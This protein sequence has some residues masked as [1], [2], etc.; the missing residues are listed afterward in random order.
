MCLGRAD[1]VVLWRVDD[2]AVETLRD[3]D[4]L[5]DEPGLLGSDPT[6]DGARDGVDVDVRTEAREVSLGGTGGTESRGESLS[7]GAGGG[8]SGRV[9]REPHASFSI[10]RPI[11]PSVLSRPSGRGREAMLATSAIPSLGCSVHWAHA[12]LASCP[13]APCGLGS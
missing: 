11:F 12:A 6:A 1:R 3:M 7:T 5:M 10:P 9:C 4:V 8:E 2:A 13:L